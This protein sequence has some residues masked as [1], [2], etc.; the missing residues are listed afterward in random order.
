MTAPTGTRWLS[1]DLSH[2]YTEAR[3]QGPL[4]FDVVIVGSGYGGAMAAA[5]LAGRTDWMG[6]A[7]RVLVLERGKEYVPGMFPS[8]GQ[9]L[10]TH[11]RIHREKSGETAGWLDGLFDIRLGPDVCALVGNGL[12]G[13]S[14]INAGVMEIP[15]WSSVPR[16]PEALT[17]DLTEEAMNR[18]KVRLGAGDGNVTGAV[19]PGDRPYLDNTLTA[20][21]N[22]PEG[23]AKTDALKGLSQ[24]KKFR[25]A[26]ITVAM[27]AQ[28]NGSPWNRCELCGDCMTGCNV[29]AKK[30]LDTTLLL[31][32]RRHGALIYTGASV[33][34]LKRAEKAGPW[35]LSVVFTTESLRRRHSPLAVRAG[36]VILAAGTLGSPEIL[37]RSQSFG[38]KFSPRLGQQFSCNGDNIL[39][40]QQ[41]GQ[42]THS[43]ADEYI[44]LTGRKVGPTITGV[45]VMEAKQS[46]PGFLIQEFAIPG[47]LKRIFNEIVTTSSLLN[48]LTTPDEQTHS[49]ACRGHDPLAVDAGKMGQVLLLGII[50]HD[51]SNGQLRLPMQDKLDNSA[52]MEGHIHIDWPEA[53]K[54]RLVDVAYA[55][56]EEL[57]RVTGQEPPLLPNPLWRMLPQE[58]DFVFRS[59]RGPLLTVHPLGGCPIGPSRNEGVVDD[60][61]RVYDMGARAGSTDMHDGLRVLDGSIVPSS[62]GANPSLTIAA[63]AQRAALQLAATSGWVKGAPT[64]GIPERPRSRSVQEC[65]PAKPAPTTVELVEKLCGPVVIDGERYMAELTLQYVPQSLDMLATDMDRRLTV[66]GE[67]STLRIYTEQAWKLQGIRFLDEGARSGHALLE[68]QVTGELTL[69]QR[70]SSFAWWR[71]IRGIA[72]YVVNRGLRDYWSSIPPLVPRQ[73]WA[74]RLLALASRAGEVRRFDYK[75]QVGQLTKGQSTSLATLIANNPQVVGEKRFTYS[76]HGNPWRQLTE[77][78]LTNFLGACGRQSPVLTLDGRFMARQAIP[79]ARIVTQENQVHALAE[80][81]SFGLYFLR[82]LVSTHV[83]SFRAPPPMPARKRELLPGVIKVKGLEP[84][85]VIEIEL[86]PPRHGI[87]VLVR[88]TRYKGK[89]ADTDGDTKAPLLLIHGYSASGSSF[90]HKSIPEPMALYF[91]NKGRDVWV[92]DLR[93]SAGMPSAVLPWNFEDAALADIPVAVARILF[94]TQRKQVD[95]FAHCIGAVMLSMALLVDPQTGSE[96]PA[97]WAHIDDVDPPDGV[98]PRRYRKELAVLGESIHKIVLS[99]KGPALVYSDGNVLRGYLMRLLRGLILPQNYQFRAPDQ[100]SRADQALD[101]LLSSL[102]YPDDELRQE[103]PTWP[104]PKNRWAG[105]RHRLDALYSRAFRLK[106]MKCKTLAALEDLFGPLNLDTVSQAVHFARYNKITNGAGRNCFVTVTRMKQRWPTGGTLSIHGEENGLADVATLKEMENL[107]AGVVPDRHFKTLRIPGFGHQDC[108]IGIGAREKVFDPVERF[109]S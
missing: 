1:N 102:P 10:P 55:R 22:F 89:N 96:V 99:Q 72:A 48:E 49:S 58:L 47:S 81:A 64:Q 73:G 39:A 93:T 14:L 15:D 109:L 103:N 65:T 2:L 16:M 104:W 69:L 24:G 79:L 50:G 36:Q 84:P 66:T 7:I 23:T 62:L 27:S 21:R 20:P 33:T 45:I 32:A 61:G 108:L 94:V 98:M 67:L 54:S 75:L 90:T 88:L 28:E 37:M 51:E 74:C 38:L 41:T 53:R 59:E 19:G 44:P 29:G 106:N 5:E 35:E 3:T 57:I 70:E 60:Y 4:S 34:S 6:N 77:L 25:P 97:Q 56:V 95:V 17:R 100:Q 9:E 83:W 101:R 71:Q 87:P 30:S 80:A 13:G 91:W 68:G 8:S 85:E 86:E 78:R 92:V 76:C 63:I 26:A 52:A 107:M 11:V 12:G 31:E 46:D 18:V 82:L 43:I 40:V 105:F 42:A